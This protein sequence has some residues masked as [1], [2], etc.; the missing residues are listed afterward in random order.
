MDKNPATEQAVTAVLSP[1]LLKDPLVAVGFVQGNPPAA[2]VTG[3]RREQSSSLG[4]TCREQG[5][6]S[7]SLGLEESIPQYSP[8][9][10]DKQD[11]NP[12]MCRQT[13]SVCSQRGEQPELMLLPA[14]RGHMQKKPS[15]VWS[16][17]ILCDRSILFLGVFSKKPHFRI[18]VSSAP[19]PRPLTS[20]KNKEES[21]RVDLSPWAQPEP[22]AGWGRRGSRERAQRLPEVLLPLRGCREAPGPTHRGVSP[23]PGGLSPSS[24]LLTLTFWGFRLSLF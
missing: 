19:G 22:V 14:V 17:P 21:D 7:P 5:T 10:T 1:A 24:A 3:G 15:D 23:T 9:L 18:P 12:L 13:E 6:K 8:A 2:P 11:F 4:P 20:L 16:A